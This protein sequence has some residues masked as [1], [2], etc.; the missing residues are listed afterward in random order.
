MFIIPDT[1]SNQRATVPILPGEK[2]QIFQLNLCFVKQTCV[3]ENG[4]TTI[5]TSISA[6]AREAEILKD[7][8]FLGEEGE[9]L[10]F[11]Y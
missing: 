8:Q 7:L 5:P 6:K 9:L 3:E 4:T 11:K 10:I 1:S 2:I